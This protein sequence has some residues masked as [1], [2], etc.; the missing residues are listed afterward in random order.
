MDIDKDILSKEFN[1]TGSSIKLKKNVFNTNLKIIKNLQVLQ[2]YNEKIKEIYKVK[3]YN[4]AIE[5][6]KKLK[7]DINKNN[8]QFLLK[9]KLLGKKIYLKIVEFLNSG[10]M[11]EVQTILKNAQKTN[12][13]LKIKGIGQK[14]VEKLN[15]KKIYNISDLNK[16]T[17]LLNNVQKIGLKYQ[18]DLNTKIPR[19]EI[20]EIMS[21]FK[22]YL[23]TNFTIAGSYRRK[24]DYSNDIDLIFKIEDILK[25]HSTV[26][27]FIEYIKKYPYYIEA[28][29]LGNIKTS[30]LIKSSVSKLIRQIDIIIIPK[31]FYYAALLYFTGN[32]FFNE[33]IRGMLKKQNYTLNEYYLYD[34]KN[35]KKIIIPN[36]EYIFRIL[37]LKY[38]QPEQRIK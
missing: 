16:N 24:Q 34:N 18:K 36:E 28:I 26:A 20:T 30:I 27:N 4:N 25:T 6:I 13:L 37:K 35:N 19:S 38:L 32:K 5:S 31:R 33:R 15:E 12:E 23:K 10:K 29:S 14:Q 9:N 3:A 2:K 8:V 17:Q 22:I 11:D 1:Y 21:H 7:F